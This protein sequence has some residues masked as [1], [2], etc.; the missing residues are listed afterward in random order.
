[1]LLSD[2]IALLETYVDDTV[3]AA[4][5]VRWLNAGQNKMAT[6]VR[7]SL[8]QLTVTPNL[9]T[10]F[11]FPEKFHETP[12]LYAAAMYKAQDSAMQEKESY[13]AQFYNGLQEFAQNYDPP[14]QYRDDPISQQFT[15]T[16]AQTDFVITKEG[17]DY[18]YGNLRVYVNNRRSSYFM[19]IETGFTYTS[20]T[21]LVAGDYVTA[22]WD[23][24]SDFTTPPALY[25]GW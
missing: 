14:A 15:A 11:A 9:D 10:S 2:M 21:P 4:D 16:A 22:V 25:P 8:P 18:R 20:L 13:L 1:M 12:V 5:A 24:H 23:E 7:A 17:Y 3:A 6:E 19:P